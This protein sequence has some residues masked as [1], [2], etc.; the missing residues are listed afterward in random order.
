[1]NA[2]HLNMGSKHSSSSFTNPI[3]TRITLSPPKYEQLITNWNTSNQLPIQTIHVSFTFSYLLPTIKFDLFLQRQIQFYPNLFSVVP[4][5]RTFI[6]FCEWT[7]HCYNLTVIVYMYRLLH[8][9][10]YPTIA[11]YQCLIVIHIII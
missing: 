2:D 3:Y 5:Y 8:R 9:S 1:M 6:V 7:R 4:K 11:C 10:Q